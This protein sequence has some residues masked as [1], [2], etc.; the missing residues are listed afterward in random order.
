MLVLLLVHTGARETCR[1]DAPGKPLGEDGGFEDNRARLP[2]CG[3]TSGLAHESTFTA[4]KDSQKTVEVRAG[5]VRVDVEDVLEQA[6]VLGVR[7]RQEAQL[8]RHE[9]ARLVRGV[10][11]DGGTREANVVVERIDV[12]RR[13]DEAPERVVL[14]RVREEHFAL[15]LPIGRHCRMGSQ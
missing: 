6:R 2:D 12:S 9:V 5:P 15:A 8:V 14:L 3:Q 4:L 11:L 7:L 13:A 1:H 10:A